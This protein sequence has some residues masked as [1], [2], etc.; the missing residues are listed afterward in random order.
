[1]HQYLNLVSDV[2]LHGEEKED[3]TGTG[4]ISIFGHQS[5]YDLR[6]GF[7]IVT[8]KKIIFDSVVRELLWFISG[9]TNVN[10]GL[11]PYTKIWDAW[12]DKMGSIG[13]GY[14]K[15]WRD[16]NGVDQL[17]EAINTIK[18]NPDSRRI[19][20]NSWNVSDLPHMALPP[21][22]MLYQFYCTKNNELDLQLYQRSGDIAL[23]VPFNITS[24]SLL[25]S[26][27]AHVTNKTPRFFIHTIGDAHI[28][29]NHVEGLL[30]QLNRTPKKLPQ[31]YFTDKFDSI[32]DIKFENIVLAN[33]IHDPFIKFDVAV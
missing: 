2:L 7:P 5:R 12:A 6:N 29:K 10:D 13:P 21:C 9:S 25:L 16:W 19:I 27:V 30:E 1:M 4:T 11:R 31:V 20:V 3:R 24:Y 26:M 23:G 33:Y 14:G 18:T 8:T 32:D 17:K 22:H 28:Y 15:Q